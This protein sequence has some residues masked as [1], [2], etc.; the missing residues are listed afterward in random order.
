MLLKAH[1]VYV[2]LLTT[3]STKTIIC[4]NTEKI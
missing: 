3:K 2:D 1:G 4:A